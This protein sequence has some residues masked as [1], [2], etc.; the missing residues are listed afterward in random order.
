MPYGNRLLSGC[1]EVASGS[2]QERGKVSRTRP[3]RH[4][5][6]RPPLR[7]ERQ[8][9]TCSFSQY[10]KAL[11]TAEATMK[12]RAQ[13]WPGFTAASRVVS[14]CKG[15]RTA[16]SRDQKSLNILD[17]D[18]RADDHWPAC[19]LNTG[20]TVRGTLASGAEKAQ[21]LGAVTGP[22]DVCWPRHTPLLGRKTEADA[23]TQNADGC[24]IV[25]FT[26][27]VAPSLCSMPT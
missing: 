23:E 9:G 13:L 6:S 19:L 16:E 4:C 21:N 11:A 1:G 25:A 8:T 14:P 7:T 3:V 10:R 17:K 20:R 22:C 24:A 2:R 27:M 15:K 18:Y 5:S 12:F 26:C